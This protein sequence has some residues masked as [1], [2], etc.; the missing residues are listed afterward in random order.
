VRPGRTRPP[1]R[2]DGVNTVRLTPTTPRSGRPRRGCGWRRTFL[3]AA[4]A[5]RG[6]SARLGVKVGGW[7]PDEVEPADALPLIP[8]RPRGTGPDRGAARRGRRNRGGRAFRQWGMTMI[9]REARPSAARPPPGRGR[10]AYV[11]TSPPTAYRGDPDRSTAYSF[12]ARGRSCR[13]PCPPVV[14]PIAAHMVFDRSFCSRGPV[15]TLE[16]VGEEPALLSATGA[17]RSRCRSDEGAD[18]CL[19]PPREFVR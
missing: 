5:P 6:A 14:T 15:V 19:E 17:R 3:R 8:R 16:V 9:S 13:P 7:V 10:R 18:P 2:D 1:I 12:S 4:F 11:T